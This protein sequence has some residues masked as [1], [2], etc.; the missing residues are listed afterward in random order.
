VETRALLAFLISVAILVGYQVL[1]AP[2]PREPLESAAPAVESA[3]PPVVPPVTT[4]SAPEPGDTP[5]AQ[6]ETVE[7]ETELYRAVFTSAGGRI[8]DFELM[9]HRLAPDPDSPPLD[10]VVSETLLPLGVY[11]ADS[12]GTVRSDLRVQYTVEP[13]LR[14]LAAGQTGTL[15]MKGRA[16]DG[17]EITKTV[18]LHGDS[19]VLDYGVEISTAPAAVGVAWARALPS[20]DGGQFSGVEGPVAYVDGELHAHAAKDLAEPVIYQG[21]T[22]WGGYA[23]HYFLAAYY[24]E[25]RAPL[26]FVGAASGNVGEV[27]LWDDAA[28][29]RVSYR[30]FVGP[31]KIRLLG[32]VGHNLQEAVDLGWFAF[33]ARPLLEMMIFLHR[34]TGNYGWAIVLLTVGIRIVFY[35]VN[36]RQLEAMK[37][38]QRVQPELKRIQE[39]YKDDR[40]KLNKGMI[41]VYRRHKVNP[42]SGCL[43]MLLQLP[44]FLGLYNA[45]MQSIELR[46]APFVGWIHDLSQ[47]DRLGALP[48]PLV[49]PPGIPVLTLLMGASMVVQQKM[50]PSTADPV[51][52]RMMMLMPVVFTVMFI[53]FPAGLVLYWFANNVLSIAQQQL[54]TRGK[55]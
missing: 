48:I 38:M 29:G 7:V 53:N 40:E 6:G 4:P 51:Q 54:M 44:V 1:F 13:D 9:E 16:A 32:A 10:M 19:Y 41:E 17:T 50:T 18:V 39:K 55:A 52:Q 5:L 2:A 11:W 25:E 24:P 35:P 27:V 3:R 12:G 14:T 26:R 31:K 22:D 37:A 34:F 21:P 8:Q 45:L 15:V 28:A 43:P 46:H 42:L 20:I 30:L 49:S 36:K 47:P 23:D 33:V